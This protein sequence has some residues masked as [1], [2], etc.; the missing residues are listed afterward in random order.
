[1][2]NKDYTLLLK[3]TAVIVEHTI[4]SIQKQFDVH[5]K[6]TG[7]EIVLDQES[8][9]DIC[10]HL[11]LV[12]YLLVLTTADFFIHKKQ[13]PNINTNIILEAMDKLLSDCFGKVSKAAMKEA[14]TFVDTIFSKSKGNA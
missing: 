6:D 5:N 7:V 3:D 13:D 1:M 11:A 14:N 12:Y 8:F 2:I 10:G 4:N 9:V